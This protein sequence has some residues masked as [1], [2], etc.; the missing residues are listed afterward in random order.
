MG[1]AGHWLRSWPE[2]QNSL[3]LVTDIP[4]HP[5]AGRAARCFPGKW[6]YEVDSASNKAITAQIPV[7]FFEIDYESDVWEPLKSR[8]ENN[9]VTLAA[10]KNAIMPAVTPYM[11][12][13][14]E[15]HT[16][17]KKM[18][19]NFYRLFAQRHAKLMLS[20]Q[21]EERYSMVSQRV[22]KQLI[23]SEMIEQSRLVKSDGRPST[24]WRWWKT[25]G[26]SDQTINCPASF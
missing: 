6:A 23:A 7:N 24:D 19:H 9:D 8:K 16:K 17:V 12:I 11:D 4:Y 22:K 1:T 10:S 14:P 25:W 26:R 13:L 18:C 21:S 5:F 2:R 15:L 3:F 20:S